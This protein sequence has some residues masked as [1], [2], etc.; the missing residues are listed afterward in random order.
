[1]DTILNKNKAINQPTLM[2]LPT[3]MMKMGM[4]EMSDLL[5][6]SQRVVPEHL[7]LHGFKFRYLDLDSTLE[8]V[9]D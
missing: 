6:G 7:L 9:L 3:F 4:G 1:V 8:N 2:P 5:L